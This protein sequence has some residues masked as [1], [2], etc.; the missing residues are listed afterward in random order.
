MWQKNSW[1][2]AA[3]SLPLVMAIAACNNGGSGS[4]VAVISG[5]SPT[6]SPSPTPT[7]TPSA[8]DVTPCL[9]QTIPGTT[10]TVGDLIIPDTL[11]LDLSAPAGFPNGR[12]LTDPVIDMTL[13]V[14]FLKLSVNGP[15]TLANLPVN[16]AA[17]DVPF[18][19]SFPYLA[20]AQG[21]PPLS[22]TAGSTF[23]FRTDPDSAYVRVDRMGMPAVATALIGSSLKNAYNDSDPS[24]D[25]ALRFFPE[26]GTQLGH[27]TDSLAD[28]F[29]RLGLTPCATAL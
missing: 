17:N 3:A 20:P 9:T 8:F 11:T 27:L 4:P 22:G 26:L 21:S 18:R 14:I 10:R 13:N 19:A 24:N 12:G 28:D 15:R 2:R 23:N 29:V 7:P 6:P 25:S 5:S 1:L 16:P